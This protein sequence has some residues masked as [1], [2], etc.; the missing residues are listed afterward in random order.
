MVTVVWR[1]E[2]CDIRVGK[3]VALSVMPL[4][5]TTTITSE[6]EVVGDGVS[7]IVVPSVVKV[8]TTVTGGS[9]IVS[10]PITVKD[11]P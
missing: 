4:V 2:N 5:V 9:G 6:F 10:D 3:K 11:V 7:V 1:V 8:E